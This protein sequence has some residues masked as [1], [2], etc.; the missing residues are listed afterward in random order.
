MWV[1]PGGLLYPGQI[2]TDNLGMIELPHPLP[3]ISGIKKS[4]QENTG[5]L[6][7]M[8]HALGPLLSLND[9]LGEY[10]DKTSKYKKRRLEHEHKG[11]LRG[12]LLSVH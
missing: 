5:T 7:H 2:Q 3:Y 9:G 4:C 1:K 8:D 10:D 12:Q 6:G 11:S